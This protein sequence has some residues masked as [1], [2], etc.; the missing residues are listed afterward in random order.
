MIRV[1]IIGLIIIC[2]IIWWLVYTAGDKKRNERLATLR[3]SGD[4]AYNQTWGDIIEN[5]HERRVRF[6]RENI[7]QWRRERNLRPIYGSDGIRTEMRNDGNGSGWYESNV[8]PFPPD[9]DLTTEMRNIARRDT[10]SIAASG[11]SKRQVG[12]E[13]IFKGR[14]FRF[15]G[16]RWEYVMDVHEK[17]DFL[18][19][20]DM[21]IE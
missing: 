4:R 12:D 14:K 18:T 13:K 11:T 6:M 21:V 7:D 5:T 17:I 10:M 16:K 8:R 1:I 19:K 2:C 15:D 9:T 3:R 20:E